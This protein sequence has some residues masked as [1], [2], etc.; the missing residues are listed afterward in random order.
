MKEDLAAAYFTN[1]TKNN[2]GETG[3]HYVI[4]EAKADEIY[5]VHRIMQEAFKQYN[6]IL[7][8][9]SSAMRETVEDVSNKIKDHGGAV[10]VWEGQEAIG[11]ARYIFRDNY[12]YIGRV[13]VL[14]EYR[15]RGIG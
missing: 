5:I 1:P 11:S 12:M 9:P 8:P 13:S 10:I 14:A 15:G 2:T 7:H 6:G 4:R 3:M